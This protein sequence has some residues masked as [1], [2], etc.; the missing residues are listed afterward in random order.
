MIRKKRSRVDGNSKANT[1]AALQATS[2]KILGLLAAIVLAHAPAAAQADPPPQS[3]DTWLASI[4]EARQAAAFPG[5]ESVVGTPVDAPQQDAPTTPTDCKAAFGQQAA[6][7]GSSYTA[8]RSTTYRGFTDTE[9]GKAR[10]I[11][12]I[13][14]SVGLY[15]DHRAAQ[16]ALNRLAPSLAKCTELH[17][18]LFDFTTSKPDP[19]TIKLVASFHTNAVYE[20]ESSTLVYVSVMGIPNSEQATQAILDR[21]ASRI[22]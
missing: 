11:V 5:L 16:E 7:G 18:K 15:A 14:Q 2:I 1:Y 12:M 22:A 6:Y 4:E 13:T 19:S 20:V 9:P 10:G 8:F 3:I 17:D 21:I